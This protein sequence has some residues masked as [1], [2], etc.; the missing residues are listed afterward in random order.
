MGLPAGKYLS[1]SASQNE[2]DLSLSGTVMG[3]FCPG[4]SPIGD[5]VGTSMVVVRRVVASVTGRLGGR[6]AVTEPSSVTLDI[7]SP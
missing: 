4:F 7:Q 1:F 3:S 6:C 5:C 2:S